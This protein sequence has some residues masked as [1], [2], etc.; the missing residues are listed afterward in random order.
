MQTARGGVGTAAELPARMEFGVDHLNPRQP[1]LR[2]LVDRNPATVV[3]HFS[4]VVGVQSH[5]DAGCR[6]GQGLIDT[7]INDLPQAMHQPP[8]VG[9]AD[10]HAWALADRFQPLQD[11]EVLGVVGLVDGR[12]FSYDG[13]VM[14]FAN[15][16]RPTDHSGSNTP[17]R[18]AHITT[19]LTSVETA[20]AITTGMV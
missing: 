15:V 19:R 20:G 1:G 8:C 9:G 7:V 11:Q 13:V 4:G 17:R 3:M 5:L 6:S 10:I 14:A 2:L 12:S 16:P 18:L